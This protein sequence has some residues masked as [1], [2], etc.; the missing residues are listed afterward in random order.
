V[1]LWV[2]EYLLMGFAILDFTVQIVCQLPMI[3]LHKVYTNIGLRKIWSYDPTVQSMDDVFSFDHLVYRYN[4]GGVDT[5]LK[6]QPKSLMLQMLN[7]IIISIITLQT[8]I[9]K[10]PGYDKYVRQSDGSMDML[11]Q[12]ADLKKKSITFVFNNRKI[13]KILSI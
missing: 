10:S 5:G 4:T 12:L 3:E 8:E 11:V 2:I 6:I 7:C 13:R 1:M 9:F